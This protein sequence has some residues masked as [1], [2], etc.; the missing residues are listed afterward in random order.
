MGEGFAE[1]D[2]FSD[3]RMFQYTIERKPVL[4]I[5]LKQLKKECYI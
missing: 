4:G 3:P 5:L 2:V 1:I